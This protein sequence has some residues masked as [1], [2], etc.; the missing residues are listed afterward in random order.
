M[1]WD[2]GRLVVV[3]LDVVVKVGGV[4]TVGALP[5]VM[6]VVL[7]GRGKLVMGRSMIFN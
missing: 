4:G 3:M 5:I 2:I 1:S 6:I 7:P